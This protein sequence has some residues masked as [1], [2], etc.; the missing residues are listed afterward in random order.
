MNTVAERKKSP[1]DMIA[2]KVKVKG[3]TQNRNRNTCAT[4]LDTV[5]LQYFTQDGTK[6]EERLQTSLRMSTP[7]DLPG[8]PQ[9]GT[10][11]KNSRIVTPKLLSTEL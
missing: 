2:E 9:A 8:L 10:I 1:V 7:M 11:F 6:R 3:R 4:Q 5:S